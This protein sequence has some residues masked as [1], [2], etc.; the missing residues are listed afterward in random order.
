[1]TSGGKE[2]EKKKSLET[3]KGLNASSTSK[4]ER[5]SLLKRVSR[6]RAGG[7]KTQAEQKICGE[8]L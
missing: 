5:E 3:L 4:E 1:M 6:Q 7:K 8:K 2:R